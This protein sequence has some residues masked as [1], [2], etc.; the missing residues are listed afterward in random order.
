MFYYEVAILGSAL[1]PLTYESKN[2]F[3]D[4]DIVN[5]NLRNKS[6]LGVIIQ[7]VKKPSFKTL[8]I[9]SKSNLK[10]TQLQINL[11]KFISYY[12]SSFLG[13][14]YD[15]FEPY[16]EFKN[17]NLYIQ[18]T[19]NLNE[20][21]KKA[22]EFI[23]KH[24]VS[25]LFG[26]T[27]S[28]KSEVYI[29]HIAKAINSGKTALFLMPEIS[30]TPQMQ[31]RLKQYFGDSV[32][33][34]HSKINKNKKAQIL[35]KLQ[36]GEIKLIA[37]ARSAL[38]LPFNNLGLVIVDEEHDDSYK[39]SS[40]PHYNAR[41]LAIYISKFGVKVILGSATP[42]IT[43]IQKQPYFR[44]KGT[45]FK[46]KKEYIFDDNETSIS[47]VIIENIAKC[48][49]RKK[50]I[51]VF[52]PTRANFKFITCK[53]CFSTIKCPYCS[54]S[55]SYHKRENMLKCHYCGYATKVPKIC[56]KCGG[57]MLEAKK[58]GTSEVLIKLSEIFP[59]AKIAKFDRD[60]ITTQKKLENIL[61]DFNDKKIDILVGT[62]MLSKG[63]DYHNVELA[64]ILGLDEYL[65]YSDFRAREKTLALAM[66]VAGRAG[67]LEYGKVIFQTKKIDFFKKFISDYDS[68]INEEITFRDPLYP[69]FS[70]LM[71][72][73]ILSKK[74]E[75]A[76]FI[77]LE[78]VKILEKFLIKMDD[79]EIIGYGKSPIELIASKF[80]Y[81]ILLRAKSHKPL[82]KISSLLQNKNIDIDIDPINF[83]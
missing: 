48:L 73:N 25:L 17:T 55:M 59:E 19:P 36:N 66:Q 32:G 28:G 12:Y 41:D 46:S 62:Q 30:L 6:S 40:N 56:D 35:S 24:D 14:S 26:D 45:F 65:E 81:N 63:H 53:S 72:I 70:K 5:I 8:P 77:C 11:A 68:F 15:L 49:E 60:E 74:D 50:Q 33:V 64:V 1:N 4:G 39:S 51:V 37:G 27:G 47:E 61:K 71:R 23:D 82:I 54:V 7:E 52:L 67:R 22:F 76:N 13:V 58:I 3:L 38:F 34:W 78:C 29:S 69:P 9:S 79:F 16:S 31:K 18:K 75:E 80:R 10:F 44:M 2:E 42:C 83:S 57:D 20:I 21:Q 43:T